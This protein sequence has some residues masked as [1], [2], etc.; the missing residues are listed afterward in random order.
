[1]MKNKR[2][3]AF[4]WDFDG[5][6]LDSDKVRVEGFKAVLNDY[7]QDQVD[8]LIQFHNKNGGLSRYV[9]FRYFFEKL[10]H[11][12]VAAYQIAELSEKFSGIMRNK[13]V[14]KSLLIA[15]TIHYISDCYD[16][17]PMHIVSG[18]DEKELRFLCNELGIGHYF[19]SI[20]GSPIPKTEL[21]CSILKEEN[22]LPGNCVLIG[23][24]INDYQ[25]ANKNG[26]QFMAYNNDDLHEFTTLT[27]DFSKA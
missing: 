18:S 25:A 26:L 6:L 27:L 1:M 15:E 4:F 10:R 14:D 3:Q 20:K 17:W 11:E 24:S 9:K 12:T 2:I 16:R 21:I 7:P 13:L 8:E 19:K 22:Y 5:V 23:D